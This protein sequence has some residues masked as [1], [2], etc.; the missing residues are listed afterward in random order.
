MSVL[1][2]DNKIINDTIRGFLD[3]KISVYGDLKYSY[4]IL[5]KKNPSEMDIVSNYP[6]E[7]VNIYKGNNYQSIDPVV[8]TA[9]NRVSPFSWDESLVISYGL[10]FSQIFNFSKK[11]NVV[12]GFTFVLH[13][14][15]N[16][17]VMLS[18]MMDEFTCHKLEHMIEVNMSELQMLLISAHEK[19]TSLYREV[20]RT[21]NNISKSKDIFSQRENEILYWASNGKTYQE[22]SLILGIKMGTVKFHIGNVVKKLGVLNA[23]HAI[24]LGVELQLIK[25]VLQ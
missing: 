10:K 22:I 20:I 15:C 5:N 6:E 11:Y 4:F 13:D 8:I 24:K 21:N 9:L 25:P 23:K 2:Y 16:N 12:N 19:R 14:N 7:W 17:L 18:I 3:R 1:S